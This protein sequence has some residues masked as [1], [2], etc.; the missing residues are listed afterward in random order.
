MLPQGIKFGLN[1]HSNI[2][3]VFFHKN[4]LFRR[5]CQKQGQTMVY[6]CHPK[7]IGSVLQ[8][9]FY[10]SFYPSFITWLY[11]CNLCGC[12][13][14]VSGGVLVQVHAQYL[15]YYIMKQIP[16]LGSC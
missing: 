6:R 4:K 3:K 8:Q 9:N 14:D 10:S 1:P 11:P 16:T 12:Q 13:A 5:A 2:L 15:L 7:T